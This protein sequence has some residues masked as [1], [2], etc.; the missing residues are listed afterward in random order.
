MT[1][2][3][4][5]SHKG[6]AYKVETEAEK[7]VGTSI[8]ETVK[9]E[10]VSEELAGYELE[11]TGTSD[12]SGFTGMSNIEGPNLK[13]ALLGYGKGMH[14]KPKGE[15]KI[16]RKPKGLRLRKTVRGKEISS[17]TVQINTK[18]MKEGSKKFD[19]LF[20]T[21]APAEDAAS[22]ETKE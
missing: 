8:G 12:K 22:E 20:K 2:K 15:G 10:D 16:N 9:G 13:K 18:V 4:N 11:I 1:F 21:E 7:L 5:V 3:I 17:A 14:M 6:K 19:D